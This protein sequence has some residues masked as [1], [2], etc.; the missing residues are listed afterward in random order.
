VQPA[1]IAPPP[2]D[3]AADCAAGPDYPASD[4]RLDELLDIQAQREA[5]A[6][7]CR[8]RH[9]ALVKAWPQ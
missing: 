1:S 8:R 9:A 7:D 5:A 2:A 3:L 6:A 4:V